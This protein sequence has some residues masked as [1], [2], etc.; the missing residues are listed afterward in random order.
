VSAEQTVIHLLAGIDNT[1]IT[2]SIDA[3]N[4]STLVNVNLDNRRLWSEATTGLPILVSASSCWQTRCP[5]FEEIWIEVAKI[6]PKGVRCNSSCCSTIDSMRRL[7]GI[8]AWGTRRCG[9]KSILSTSK[10]RPT[11]SYLHHWNGTTSADPR[12][13]FS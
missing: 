4:L 10:T 7:K 8:R 2:S 5:S 9:G 1:Q 12:H 11:E 3:N 6:K 13:T